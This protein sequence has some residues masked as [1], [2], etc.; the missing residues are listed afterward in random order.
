MLRAVTISRRASRVDRDTEMAW[1]G[2][3]DSR[4]V[5][6]H[7]SMTPMSRVLIYFL[8]PVSISLALDF[9]VLHSG[10]SGELRGA[11]AQRLNAL[12]DL[13]SGGCTFDLEW[14]GV[15][16]S[17]CRRSGTAQGDCLAFDHHGCSAI[18]SEKNA[19]GASQG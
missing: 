8:P 14:D 15:M 13:I 3:V 11:A 9:D 18:E 16:L 10:N 7:F 1:D 6:A 12:C 2:A 5:Q 17:K 4:D 19:H